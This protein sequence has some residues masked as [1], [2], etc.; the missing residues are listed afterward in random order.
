MIHKEFRIIGRVTLARSLRHQI[1]EGNPKAI[2]NQ[3]QRLL[4]LL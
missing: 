2:A 3:I 1:K 4:V